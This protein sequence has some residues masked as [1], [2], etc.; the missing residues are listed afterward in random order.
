MDTTHTN[1]SDSSLSLCTLLTYVTCLAF[2]PLSVSIPTT[3]ILL[4]TNEVV[5]HDAPS[6]HDHLQWEREGGEGITLTCRSCSL[7]ETTEGEREKREEE[8][9]GH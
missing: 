7:D 6:S 2:S 1:G 5:F 4:F 8:F 9:S 3:R